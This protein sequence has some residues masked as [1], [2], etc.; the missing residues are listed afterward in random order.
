MEKQE[1]IAKSKEVFEYHKNAKKVI[2]TG[3]GNFFLPEALNLANDHA[4]RNGVQVFEIAR[5]SSK[6]G[7]SIRDSKRRCFC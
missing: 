1:L 3:D 4:R 7:S 2:A 5:G 6:W